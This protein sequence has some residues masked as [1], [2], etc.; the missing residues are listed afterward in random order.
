MN[1]PHAYGTNVETFLDE[2]SETCIEASGLS[3]VYWDGDRSLEIFKNVS[4][5]VKKGEGVAILGPS[6]SGKT[7]LLNILS[8]L[9]KP[10]AGEVKLQG[11]SLNR[12]NEK[13]KAGFRNKTIGFIFQFYHLLSEF[14]ALENVM[15]PALI[16]TN[17]G[18]R[19][20]A[21][22]KAERL[23]EKVGLKERIRHFP[24]ELSGGEQQRVAIARSL[25]NDPNILFCDEPTGNLDIR[26]G[27]EIAELLRNLFDQEGKTVLVVT[28][29]ERIARMTSRVWNIVDRE[30]H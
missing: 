16:R 17:G 19:R 25:V 28:H 8:G 1:E 14:T 12:M 18:F 5:A 4:I 22:K 15:L 10:N 2:Q 3:K 24:G 27:L 23:L 26:M 7:T 20:E 11:V 29:D 9:D 21:E 30:W 6:G 13:E